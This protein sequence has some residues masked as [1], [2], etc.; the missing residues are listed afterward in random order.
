MKN[1]PREILLIDDEEDILDFL[2]H[3]LRKEGYDIK[4]F[5]NPLPALNYLK[6]AKPSLIITDL[7]MPEMDGYELFIFFKA[8]DGT[9]YIP[10]FIMSCKNSDFD[11]YVAFKVGAEDYF[12]KPFK[13]K[14][15]VEKINEMLLPA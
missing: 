6:D 1:V 8:E 2:S 14:D 12:P 4:A 7:L 10:L 15:L 11:K 9:R 13:I 5:N 3:F